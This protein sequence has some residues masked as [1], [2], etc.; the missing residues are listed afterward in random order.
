MAKALDA[1]YEAG[2][3]GQRWFK[4]KPVHTLDLVVLAAEWETAGVAAGS[5]TSTLVPGMPRA[6]SS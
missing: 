6:V 2:Q 5:A 3:R 1:R 4:I